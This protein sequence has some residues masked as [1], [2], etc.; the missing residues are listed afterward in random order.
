MKLNFQALKESI[1]KE[2][3]LGITRFMESLIKVKTSSIAN[4]EAARNILISLA[5]AIVN[6]KVSNI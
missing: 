3:T 1:A 4:K 5:F 2:I 6:Q